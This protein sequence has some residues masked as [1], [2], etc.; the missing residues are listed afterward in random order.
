MLLCAAPG[1]GLSRIA[2]STDDDPTI[3][4][5]DL[6]R[7]FVKTIP[8][9]SRRGGP[10]APRDMFAAVRRP[11]R[12]LYKGWKDAYRKILD[13]EPKKRDA[14]VRLISLHLTWYNPQT[15]EFFSPVDVR[16]LHNEDYP[17]THIIVLIDDIYD[18]YSRLTKT[19]NLYDKKG[20][21][22]LIG[23]IAKLSAAPARTMSYKGDRPEDLKSLQS[24][25]S[26]S[27]DSSI[28]RRENEYHTQAVG[29]ALD[30]L[31]SWRRAEMI[32][33]EN[34]ARS[35]DCDLT[36]LGTKHTRRSLI[37]LVSPSDVP[38]IY[39]SHRITEP[40]RANI[41]SLIQT[42]SPDAWAPI[43]LEV[44]LLHRAFADRVQVLI[45]PT[46]IDELR[47]QNLSEGRRSPRLA[48]RW[49]LPDP[50]DELL[51]K[52][53]P[54]TDYHHFDIL[55]KPQDGQS[56]EIAS[57]VARSLSN[58]IYS[59]ISFRDHVI[60]ENTPSLCV[61]RPFY[62]ENLESGRSKP[63][64]SGG[65]GP[66]LNH[67][68]RNYRISGRSDNGHDTDM[69]VAFINSTSEIRERI[70][71]L[72]EDPRVLDARD[73]REFIRDHIKSTLKSWVT[74]DDDYRRLLSDMFSARHEASQ[75]DNRPTPEFAI[76]YP[77]YLIDAA[78]IAFPMAFY[79]AFTRMTRQER[80]L[81]LA[82]G[83]EGDEDVSIGT[84]I[85]AMASTSNDVVLFAVE[86]GTEEGQRR[87]LVNL[88]LLAERLCDFY[89][90]ELNAFQQNWSFWRTCFIVF[91][92]VTEHSFAAFAAQTVDVDYLEICQIAGRSPLRASDL[93]DIPPVSPSRRD[94]PDRDPSQGAVAGVNDDLGSQLDTPA[95]PGI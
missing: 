69:K 19:A 57:H 75:L 11:R 63:Q 43:A 85:E 92:E 16:H 88:D 86:E 22:V 56:F 91:E 33:A 39:L 9:K 27:Q 58:R 73:F 45:N 68:E 40:R 64:W 30:E 42:G 77:H 50:V 13:S 80:D 60:V 31:I 44:N 71:Y 26:T 87:R 59:E 62:C 29:L 49:P 81:D 1:T 65:V 83:S 20:M 54:N 2:D 34:V 12:E 48:P 52:P 84:I 6:E 74:N 78:Q 66:E 37:S 89:A 4:V 14:K 15:R 5:W 93:G 67:W 53:A 95:E 32:Q 51:W 24:G 7:E 55:H 94:P 82:D 25:N 38:R 35:L 17:V 41:E 47:F 90:G 3:D 79:H 21:D 23:G 18:M 28:D 72:I 46:A 10:Q 36:L 70:G 76:E 61:F 8:H